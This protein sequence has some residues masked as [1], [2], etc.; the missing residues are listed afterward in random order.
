VAKVSH[1]AGQQLPSPGQI[2]LD[3]VGWMVPDMAQASAML[4]ALG[5]VLTPF[6]PHLHRDPATKALMPVGTANRL[7]MLPTGY[8]EVLT[9]VDSISTPLADHLRAC[10]ARHVGVHLAAFSVTDAAT[11][12]RELASAGFTVQ[13]PMHLRRSVEAAD[14]REVEVAFTV[15][16]PAFDHFPEGRVQVL[17]H[18]TP[19]H[20]WQTRYLPAENAIESLLEVSYVADD[21]PAVAD[22]FSRFLGRPV[23]EGGPSLIDLDRGR[24]RFMSR[25]EAAEVFGARR[26]PE[27]P[28]IGAITLGSRDI[29]R[30][31]DCF[32]SGGLHPGSLGGDH[33]LIDAAEALGVHLVIVP[34]RG[35]AG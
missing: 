11:K 7:A 5:L 33:L 21:P 24:V 26:L 4:E 22:R 16:R 9:P 8:L 35:A 3:H 13:P 2:F 18:H 10:M 27:N 20:M 12:A 28:S 25:R 34:V 32:L 1:A 17:T 15:V 29:D 23:A 14:G 19:E 30:T 31:R 6:S